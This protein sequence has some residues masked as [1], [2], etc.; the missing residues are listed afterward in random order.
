MRLS[1]RG[2]RSAFTLIELL[3]VIA[4]IAILVAIL[5][6]AV[7]Q[8]REAARRAQCK[9]NLKQIGLA[10]HNY[11]DDYRMFPL[12]SGGLGQTANTYGAAG[13]GLGHGYISWTIRIL[14]YMDQ[15]AIYET[16]D[17]DTW[18]GG[19][20]NWYEL[21]PWSGFVNFEF[22]EVDMYTCPSDVQPPQWQGVGRLSYK[23]N[24]GT[25]S[26]VAFDGFVHAP[27]S[28]VNWASNS[29]GMFARRDAYAIRDVL[30]GASNTMLVAEM[31]QGNPSDVNDPKGNI[32]QASFGN[33]VPG[34]CLDTIEG[35]R[36]SPAFPG[37][38]QYTTSNTWEPIWYPGSQ[39]ARGVQGQASFTQHLPPNA[40]YC[41]RDEA[42]NSKAAGIQWAS[43][44]SRHPGG[45]QV[46]MGDGRVI[47]VNETIDAGNS[48]ANPTV[49]NPNPYGVWGA[50]GTRAVGEL[51][52]DL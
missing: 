40:P 24:I 25:A 7:Q 27:W 10:L 16:V 28:D 36:I 43:A 46:L 51:I 48:Y 6:P 22:N 14:P 31:C 2:R 11:H 42:P 30:D 39:W 12:M 8:A 13:N 45:V 50:M 5:L 34:L 20:P 19:S 41:S 23:A 15:T 47:F 32:I 1:T 33:T 18:S 52:S 29:N 35:G 37:R 49:A 3:V 21:N 26:T 44:S 4:I 17:F 38:A 9:N